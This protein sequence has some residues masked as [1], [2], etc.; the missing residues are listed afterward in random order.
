MSEP[1][2]LKRGAEEI[3]CPACRKISKRQG[4]QDSCDVY[5]CAEDHLTRVRVGT[6]KERVKP[7]ESTVEGG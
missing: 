7:V 1:T 2:E 3:E 5:R 4:A 6:F